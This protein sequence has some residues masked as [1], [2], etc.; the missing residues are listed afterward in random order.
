MVDASEIPGLSQIGTTGDSL[1]GRTMDQR[2]K[3]TFMLPGAN[4]PEITQS[5]TLPDGKPGT[6]N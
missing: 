3:A 4:Y 1:K 6:Q 2:L 5:I